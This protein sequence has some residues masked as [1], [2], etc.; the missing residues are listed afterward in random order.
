E[1]G[2][3]RAAVGSIK[4]DP[5]WEVGASSDD[6]H[7]ELGTGEWSLTYSGVVAGAN[8]ATWRYGCGMRFTNITIPRASTIDQAYLTLRAI[9]SKSANDVNTRISAEDV[10]DAPT[11]ADNAAAFDARWANRTTTRVDWDAIPAWTAGL[12]YDSPEIK[13]VIKE[14]VDRGGWNSGQDIVIFWEDFEDRSTR[15]YNVHRI[16]ASWDRDAPAPQLVI[17]YTA[18]VAYEKTLTEN[19]GLVDKVVKSPS[20]LKAEPLGLLDTYDRTWA[21]YRV[22]PEILGLS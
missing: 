18:G 9:L 11:F 8:T 21:A 10:D 14:I 5:I 4:I 12:D 19:L 2:K 22:Y 3:A 17:E 6:A 7:R 16:A 15:A 1:T 13:T 20:L